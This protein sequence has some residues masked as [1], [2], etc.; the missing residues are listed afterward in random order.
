MTDNEITTLVGLWKAGKRLAYFK[1]A[2]GRTTI[3]EV[4][5]L[6]NIGSDT[7]EP[8]ALLRRGL[9]GTGPSDYAIPLEQK[10]V[11]AD[12]FISFEQPFGPPVMASLLDELD[13]GG[14]TSRPNTDVMKDAAEE[15]RRLTK[16]AET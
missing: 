7:E 1:F 9:M 10:Y 2:D 14:S 3:Y 5:S 16:K 12:R 13:A 15:I 6:R 4:V 8:V 11:R